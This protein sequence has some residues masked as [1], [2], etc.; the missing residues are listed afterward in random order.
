MKNLKYF[1]KINGDMDI[2]A[3]IYNCVIE[4]LF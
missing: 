4:K 2:N 3:F 1:M